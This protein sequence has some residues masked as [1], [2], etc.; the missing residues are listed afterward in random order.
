MKHT[1]TPWVYEHRSGDHPENSNGGWGAIGLWGADHN[2]VLGTDVGWD[3]GFREPSDEDAAF[4]VHACNAHDELV[5]VLK[6]IIADVPTDMEG[7]DLHNW[8]GLLEGRC[9]A[10]LAKVEGK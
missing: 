1:P 3:G 5:A 9:R 7:R 8:A 2:Q 10:T 4:I 6:D